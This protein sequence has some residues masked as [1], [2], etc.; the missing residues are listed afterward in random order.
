LLQGLLEGHPEKFA[1][2]ICLDTLNRKRKLF[3][4]A[5]L[6]EVSGIDGGSPG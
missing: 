1:T 5:M 2:A 3:N 4:H 6:Q